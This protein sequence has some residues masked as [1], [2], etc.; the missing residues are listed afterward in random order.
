[1]GKVSGRILKSSD[2]KL[3][4]HFQVHAGQAVPGSPN[5]ANVTLAAP[6]VRIVEKKPEFTIVEVTCG[7]GTKTQIRCE[8]NDAQSTEQKINQTEI[9]GENDN[10]N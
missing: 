3:E 8:Y 9:S 7:C 1:M 6:Q 10:E 5:K 2:V 4:G